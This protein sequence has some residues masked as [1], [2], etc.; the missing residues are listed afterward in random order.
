MT[1]PRII[2]GTQTEVP[3]ED[4]RRW[5]LAF[6]IFL[7]LVGIAYV[8]QL[9]TPLR[10]QIDSVVLMSEAESV[11]NGTGFLDGGVK[12][13]FPPGYPAVLALLLK[14]GLAHPPVL[15]AFNLLLLGLG[16]AVLPKLL[17]GPLSQP[18]D[19][20][21]QIMC[22]FLLAFALI[23]HSAMPLTDVP[24]FGLSTA[25]VAILTRAEEQP[26]GKQFL[27][28]LFAAGAVFLAAISLRMVG[29]ALVPAF[30]WLGLS[31]RELRQI[32]PRSRKAKVIGLIAAVLILLPIGL[33]RVWSYTT[34]VYRVAAKG[35]TPSAMARAA[36]HDHALELG[37][38]VVN[39]PYRYLPERLRITPICVVG[40]G[41]II[42]VS[43]GLARRIRRLRCIDVYFIVYAC[44]ILVWPYI[45]PRFWVPVLPLIMTYARIGVTSWLRSERWT[46][47][48]TAF[49]IAFAFTGMVALVYTVRLSL[50]GPE[51]PDRYATGPLRATYCAA[52]NACN[53]KYNIKEIDPKIVHLLETYK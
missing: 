25:C 20:A 53:G 32:L 44:I 18:R 13:P 8:L 2:A 6:R 38:L 33:F 12:T 22:A 27:L 40:L 51:F 10:L 30:V 1:A 46:P 14:L 4:R 35:T 17:E 28:T 16:L 9:R 41:L 50:A 47:L 43:A 45:D 29:V 36:M 24:F 15:V 26:L 34:E 39:V 37:Q 19:V 11:A 21:L 48:L 52:M 3:P 42:A 23:K 49:K 5:L 7:L 31:R